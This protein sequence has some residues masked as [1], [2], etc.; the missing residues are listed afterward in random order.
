MPSLGMPSQGKLPSRLL[1]LSLAALMLAGCGKRETGTAPAVASAGATAAAAAANAPLSL[2]PAPVEA[3]PAAGRFTIDTGTLI[4]IPAGDA[5]ARRSADYLASLLKRTR[6]LTLEVRAEATPSPASI[7]LQ[8]SAQAPVAQKEGYSLDVTAQGIHIAARDGAGLLYGAVSAWQLMTADARQGAVTVQGVSI[9]DW[10]R[11]GWRGQHLDVARHFHDVDTVKHVLDA[12]A[13]HKLNVLHWHLTDD[14]GWRIEIKRYPKLTEVGA[15]RT[16]PGAGRHGTPERYGGFYTQ[17]Q[18]SEI[19]AYAARL[20]ITVLPEL[21]MPGHAQAAVAAYP[22]EV[23]VPGVRTPVGVDWGVNPYLFNTSER[24]LSFITHVLDEVLTLFPSTYI[25]IGGDE[26]V[27]DQW[28]ASP[29]VRAQMRKLGVKDAHAM[30][31]WFNEQL[32]TYLTQHGRRM[33]G[34]D[35]ILEGGVPASASVMSWRGVEGAVTAAR[36]GHDVVLAPGDWLYLDNLQTTRSDEPNGRLT[37]LP[38]SKVYA[39]DPVPSDLTTDQARHVLGAQGALWSEYIPSRWHVDHA[40][41]PRLS[42]VAEM[43]WSPP[44]AREW[45]NFLAR[46]P[47]QLQRYK[48]LGI[49]YSDGAFAA[50]IA[51]ESGPNPVLAGAPATVALSTQTGA[52][53]LH[54]TTDGSA[55][56]P[57]SPRYEA[58]FPITLPTT[59]KATAFAADGTPLAATRSRTF[60]RASLLRVDTQGLGHCVEQGALGLRLPL[61]PEMTGAETPVYNVDLFHACRLYPQARLDGIG[62]IRIEAARL[63]NNFGLAHE[64]SKVVQYPA[65]T[66]GGELEVRQGCDG[67]VLA[68]VQLPN[69]DTLGEQFT[70]ETPLPARTGIHDLCLR[71]TAPIRGPLYAIGA[72]QLIETTAQAPPAATR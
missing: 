14:Q 11:F 8:R 4:S 41:F 56:T 2:I 28:E 65:R 61:L 36:Q 47:A 69:S 55:P 20:H 53:T 72:V 45:K 50:D 9:R 10:P 57:A 29:A 59:V 13:V 1:G 5:D 21:D 23:G 70:L 63:P 3:K 43:T 54:Y 66:R 60:D 51:L 44:A 22:E 46:L 62:A 12:M 33:I 31:G 34:W 49:G 64:Q 7:R 68:S 15:W 27:K 42:A 17:Q 37:V 30:Q 16:P 35:E 25:H 38:L 26:A 32:A 58:P 24:S 52:G 67:D 19:V 18:I 6:G 39:F 71:F 48:A 40:L